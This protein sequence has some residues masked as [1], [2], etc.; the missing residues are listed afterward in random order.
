MRR[1]LPS[2]HL[3][4]ITTIS[5]PFQPF[6]LQVLPRIDVPRICWFDSPLN[7]VVFG[8]AAATIAEVAWATQVRVE[9][10]RGDAERDERDA[11]R[12]AERE[13]M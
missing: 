9:G 5:R 10:G 7:W 2:H 6:A 12:E 1:P 11:E 3:T 13:E 8:R 4:L